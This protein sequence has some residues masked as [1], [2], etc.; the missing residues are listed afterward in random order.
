LG[1]INVD[2]DAT[3]QP[4]TD[5]LFCI[6][7]ILE[8]KREYNKA[9]HKLFIDFMKAYDPVRRE[10]LYNIVIE[11]GIPMKLVRLIK[12]CLNETYGRVQV[13]KYLSDRFPIRNGWKT[14]VL[15][16]WLFNFALGYAIRSV[17]VNQEGFQ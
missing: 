15:S 10:V 8:K 17:Q 13:G 1:F 2:F 12:M 6:H 11:F 9:M 16:P 14:D 5:H 4:T 3:G 7:Q